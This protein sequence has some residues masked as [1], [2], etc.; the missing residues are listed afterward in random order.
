MGPPELVSVLPEVGAAVPS[1]VEL[2]V[3]VELA[4]EVELEEEV[5]GISGPPP[6]LEM[7]VVIWMMVMARYTRVHTSRITQR[8]LGELHQARA[9]N[10]HRCH[11][12]HTPSSGPMVWLS[13]LPLPL[14]L[15]ALREGG[16]ARRRGEGFGFR[17][18]R[19]LRLDRVDL[20]R[21]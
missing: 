11:S 14:L 4:V 17:G 3:A 8:P 16:E 20:F 21:V 10:R 12:W 1:E 15:T 19:V 13:E 6:A 7:K 5:L 18:A 9:Q 2:A